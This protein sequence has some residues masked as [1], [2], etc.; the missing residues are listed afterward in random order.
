M[1]I[2][3]CTG[4]EGD[5][6]DYIA[7]P[8]AIP[9]YPASD[10]IEAVKFDRYRHHCGEGDMWP[11][12]WTEDNTLLASAGDNK[13]SLMNLWRISQQGP[14]FPDPAKLTNTGDWTLDLVDNQPVDH[15]RYCTRP[16]APYIKPAGLLDVGGTV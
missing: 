4:L 5:C 15:R 13:G 1:E 10:L 2:I 14:D 6:R 11:L 3:R 8:K 16:D 9:P 12:T 7:Y